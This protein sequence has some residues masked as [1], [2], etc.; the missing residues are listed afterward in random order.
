MK[1]WLRSRIIISRVKT[2]IVQLAHLEFL[3]VTRKV[4]QNLYFDPVLTPFT[5]RAHHR[6]IADAR[7]VYVK[8]LFC[9]LYE[10][11]QRLAE[12]LSG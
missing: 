5:E 6:R 3:R 12:R 4:T 11:R 1:A 8:L 2:H 9:V 7:V 10:C